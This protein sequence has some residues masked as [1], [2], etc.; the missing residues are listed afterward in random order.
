MLSDIHAPLHSAR[1][2][3][4][5][6][7]CG[8]L[9]GCT[10]VIVNGDFIDANEISRH[11]GGYY[12]RKSELADGFKAGESLLDIF[13][14]EFNNVVFLNGNHCG[15]RL[16]KIF[17]GELEMQ[18]LW[19]M[20]GCHDNVK[21]AARSFVEVNSDIVIGHPRSYS[22]IRGNIPQKI[23][24]KWQ[25]SV[26]LGHGHHTA[27]TVTLDGRFQAV[28]IPCLADLDHFEY[29]TFEINDMPQP[30]NGFMVIFGNKM[31]VFDKFSHWPLFGLPEL[32]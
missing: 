18:R 32:E 20:F 16:I 10:T 14:Q 28:D 21:V 9:L 6:L 1:W 4:H 24:Q 7:T 30:M 17:R 11:I 23:A 5:A 31:H 2:I 27:M 26:A 8:K 3:T 13:S 19:K 25:K 22:R 15:E 29:T 12:R